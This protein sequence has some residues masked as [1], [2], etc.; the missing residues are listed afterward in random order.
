LQTSS[1]YGPEEDEEK[2][3]RNPSSK[4][5][6]HSTKGEGG[7]WKIVIVGGSPPLKHQRALK[8][9]AGEGYPLKV[10]DVEDR[11]LGKS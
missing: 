7:N 10:A 9:V 8:I 5:R 11:T 6:G 2:G 4:E 3:L 1:H